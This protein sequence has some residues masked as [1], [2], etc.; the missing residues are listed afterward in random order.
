MTGRI[1][2]GQPC[3]E[4]EGGKPSIASLNLETVS[5]FL[6]D[7]GEKDTRI[8]ERVEALFLSSDAMALSE[9]LKT[10]LDGFH[11]LPEVLGFRDLFPLARDFRAFLSD[12]RILMTPL[13]WGVALDLVDR[14][15]DLD[16][17]LEGLED[18]GGPLPPVF[19][20]A[21]D[22]WLEIAAR[23]GLAMDWGERILNHF[24]KDRF[25]VR[26]NLMRHADRLLSAEAMARLADRM[27]ADAEIKA[28]D[29]G[30]EWRR[31]RLSMGLRYL[32]QALRDAELMARS[33]TL[34]QAEP[35][36]RQ[37]GD[38]VQAYLDYEGPEAA[39]SWLA[40]DW[41]DRE[42]ERLDLLDQVYAAMEDREM[43][44]QIRRERYAAQPSADY[45]LALL[46]VCDA[47]EREGFLASA[48][49]T[50]RHTSSLYSGLNLL[51]SVEATAEAENLLIERQEA[52][53]NYD[54]T[55]V[56]RLQEKFEHA[57][58]RLGQIVCYRT[59]VEGI[60]EESRF[61]AYAKAVGYCE[62]LAELNDQ[63]SNYRTLSSHEAYMAELRTRY[64][65][66]R[67]FWQRLAGEEPEENEDAGNG[68]RGQGRGTDWQHD[69][70][71]HE[72]SG[73]LRGKK[74]PRETSGELR[75]KKVSRETSSVTP[76]RKMPRGT[77][78]GVLG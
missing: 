52:L 9:C 44:F 60:L 72:N 6:E 58:A 74:V 67:V 27:M 34:V 75:S 76:P 62:I 12:T 40:G 7:L 26:A 2:S 25:G 28:L 24:L 31:Y 36:L 8:R 71:S 10:R 11:A 35:S 16:R 78:G 33:V 23:S 20:E 51:L 50:A 22:L 55:A 65:D 17:V 18:G 54:Y 63:V 47:E 56:L 13:D 64:A 70:L 73:S 38:I 5:R 61:R 29:A 69:V 46:E 41:G 19:A 3:G 59:L 21:C 32:S 15:L 66:K 77:P 57:G 37:I 4:G 14:F 48:P 42:L 45:L 53:G 43:L 68:F 1:H 39:L 49:D 30:G